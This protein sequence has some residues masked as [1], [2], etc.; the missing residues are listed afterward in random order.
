MDYQETESIHV[1]FA[2]KNVVFY[3]VAILYVL[4]CFCYY[5]Y[6]QKLDF[7]TLFVYLLKLSCDDPQHQDYIKYSDFL[8]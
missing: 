6:L 8:F 3:N 5:V 2:N 1:I 7:I 4:H